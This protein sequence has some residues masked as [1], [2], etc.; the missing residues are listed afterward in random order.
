MSIEG[1]KVTDQTH[2]GQTVIQTSP[3][4]P[5]T[6]SLA[7]GGT[8]TLHPTGDNGPY[9][10]SFKPAGEQGIVPQNSK[11]A[12]VALEAITVT[13]GKETTTT[14]SAAVSSTANTAACIFTID[15]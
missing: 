1:I 4:D 5:T 6:V 3:N 9:T 14:T 10:V 13:H 2:V 7:A 12:T 15:D 11:T 8:T